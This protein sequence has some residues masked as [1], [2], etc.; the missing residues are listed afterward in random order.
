QNTTPSTGWL[1]DEYFLDQDSLSTVKLKW[2]HFASGIVFPTHLFLPIVTDH[3]RRI[4][5][6]W[7][8]FSS[9]SDVRQVCEFVHEHSGTTANHPPDDQALGELFENQQLEGRQQGRRMD[10]E[11]SQQWNQD[12]WPYA[13]DSSEQ[14]ECAIDLS[15]GQSLAKYLTLTSLFVL[16]MGIWLFLPI[17]VAAIGWIITNYQF[18]GDWN[19]LVSRPWSTAFAVIPVVGLM[20]VFIGGA[21]Q[22]VIRY[23]S[24]QTQPMMI[25]IRQ[26]GIYIAGK[27]FESWMSW[28]A[29]D[30]VLL[31]DKAAGWILAE[32]G[33]E[34]G[35]PA[36]C[37]SSQSDF[38]GFQDALLRLRPDQLSG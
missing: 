3:T 5:L 38:Q 36:K 10:F 19:F 32:S 7:R 25:R 11:R 17:W 8:F 9:P 21:M 2:E 29:I 16:P 33:D 15:L 31:G 28:A 23:R 18:F 30:D 13:C 35:L 24:L 12:E 27:T 26:A 20:A 37:F 4:I 34:I 1:N 22:S 14:Y 6:P